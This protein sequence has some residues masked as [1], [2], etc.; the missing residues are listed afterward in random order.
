MQS[1]LSMVIVLKEG[2]DTKQHQ[3]VLHLPSEGVFTENLHNDILPLLSVLLVTCLR[4]RNP[5]HHSKRGYT[6]S[7]QKCL[8]A[9]VIRQSL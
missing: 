2:E 7:L 8:P 4:A 5:A 1:V 6:A 3:C 9:I